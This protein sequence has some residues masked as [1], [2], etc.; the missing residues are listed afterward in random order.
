MSSI[1]ENID[2]LIEEYSHAA[3]LRMDTPEGAKALAQLTLAEVCLQ[4]AE[5]NSSEC[6][7]FLLEDVPE[8]IPLC[9]MLC[10]ERR[11]HGD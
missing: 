10:M 5:Q 2:R 3:L 7:S 6:V 8:Q 11:L 4:N 1:R 9:S